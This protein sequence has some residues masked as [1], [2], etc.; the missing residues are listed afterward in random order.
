MLY[1]TLV[2]SDQLIDLLEAKAG[3]KLSI[4]YIEYN[5]T[6]TPIITKDDAG[7]K[8]NKNNTI[9]FRGKQRNLLTQFGTNFWAEK[10]DGNIILKGD[11]VPVYVTVNKAVHS[12]LTKEIIEDRNYEIN[13]LTNYE[14]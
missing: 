7:H 8:L 12:Y 5:D 11:G 2:L 10:V 14:F 1:S 13:K 4:G 6:L 3:D 9:S